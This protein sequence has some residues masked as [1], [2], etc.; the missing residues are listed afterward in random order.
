MKKI[1]EK[2]EEENHQ[3]WIDFKPIYGP[4]KA[5]QFS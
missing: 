3:I 2:K 5:K 1:E 4:W